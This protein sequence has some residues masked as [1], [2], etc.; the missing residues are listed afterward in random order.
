MSRLRLHL[1]ITGLTLASFAAASSPQSIASFGPYQ[2]L[3]PCLKSCYWDGDP[4]G[5]GQD[6][7]GHKLGC[8]AD[9]IICEGRGADN[10]CYCSRGLFSDVVLPILVNCMAAKCGSDA[11]TAEVV[12]EAIVVYYSYCE[13]VTN[14]T[15]TTLS[16]GTGLPPGPILATTASTTAASST[17]RGLTK[18]DAT[19]TTAT[20]IIA[21]STISSASSTI[22]SASSTT[23]NGA[24]GVLSSSTASITSSRSGSNGSNTTPPA[25]SNSAISTTSTSQATTSIT[26]SFASIKFGVSR[27]VL[28]GAL[29]SAALAMA[30]K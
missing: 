7:L 3:D 2:R 6:V 1:A 16:T 8:C 9:E 4:S 24:S 26:L 12:A 10:A 14:M 11:A 22:S 28:G 5:L 13:T 15:L 21:S 27:L 17:S 29:L 23:S 30:F 20:A 18:S 19:S 25:S